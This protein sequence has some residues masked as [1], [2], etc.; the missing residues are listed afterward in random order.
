M[1]ALTTFFSLLVSVALV[2]SALFRPA[3]AHTLAEQ[4]NSAIGGYPGPMT[5]RAIVADLLAQ[6]DKRPPTAQSLRSACMSNRG[7][8]SKPCPPRLGA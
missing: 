8:G 6:A 7:C 3:S 4:T 1:T 2:T 5:L